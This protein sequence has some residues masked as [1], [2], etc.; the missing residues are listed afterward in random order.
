MNPSWE[1]SLR[2]LIVE[3]DHALG[4][5]LRTGL[6][7]EGHR[8][9][10]AEDGEDALKQAAADHPD[11]VLLDL[12]LPKRDGTEVLAEMRARHDDAA[13]L[14]LSGRNDLQARVQCLDLG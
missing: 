7:Q 9:E 4:T 5:F 14:V 12:S 10:L 6:Q 3:D 8:V 1:N 2:V 13:V 11:L